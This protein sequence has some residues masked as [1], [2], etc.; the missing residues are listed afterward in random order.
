MGRTH[1]KACAS[2]GKAPWG[3]WKEFQTRLPT[4]EELRAKW[5]DNPELNVGMTLG[6][7][8]GL[9]QPGRSL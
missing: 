7:V 3:P 4:E 2:H 5:R 9:V 6:G 1:G 8:T